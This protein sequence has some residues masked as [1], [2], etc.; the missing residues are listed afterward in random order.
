MNRIVKPANGIDFFVKVKCQ[1]RT[2]TLS[3]GI[4]YSM[5][6]L[7]CDVKLMCEEQN[8]TRTKT[9]SS[10]FATVTTPTTRNMRTTIVDMIRT[11]TAVSD[12]PAIRN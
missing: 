6:D 12:K 9:N 7:I 10:Y 8:M 11:S 3:L 4:K 5:R 2:T 1:S